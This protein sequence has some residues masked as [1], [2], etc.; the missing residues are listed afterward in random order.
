MTVYDIPVDTLEGEPITLNPFRGRVLLIVNVASRCGFTPQYSGLEALHRRHKERGFAVLGFPCNQFAHQEPGDAAQIRDFCIRSYEI[1][2]PL[3]AK[4]D[5]NGRRAH[6]LFRLLKEA[7]PGF[8]GTK[9]IKWNF[10]KFLIA[11][12]GSVLERY[13]PWVPPES[14]EPQL[15][16]ALEKR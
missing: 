10:T 7:K 11:R 6:P 16:R 13:A 14:F 15:E 2:F 5:V 8:W 4:I 3:F 1:T 9:T 12:D